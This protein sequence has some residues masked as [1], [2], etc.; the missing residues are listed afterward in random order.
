MKNNFDIDG[1]KKAA[2]SGQMDDFIDRKLSKNAAEKLRAVLSDKSATEK[3]LQTPEA[4][5][6]MK[7]LMD[8]QNG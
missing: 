6:L 3:L 2:E 8:K 7:K 5:E 4:K 1:F